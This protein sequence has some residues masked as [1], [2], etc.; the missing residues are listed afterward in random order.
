MLAQDDPDSSLPHQVELFEVG[1]R[2]GLQNE[3][4][5]IPTDIKRSLLQDLSRTG[6]TKVQVTSF[7]NPRL[8]PQLADADVLCAGLEA[9][10]NVAYSALVLN[11]RGLE[12]AMAAGLRHVDLSISASE[13]HSRRNLNRSIG[14]ALSAFRE[15]VARAQAQGLSVQGGI[16]CAFG[17]AYEGW[18]DPKRVLDL[19]E[20]YLETG[21]NELL[22]ADSTGMANPRQV[23]QLIRAVQ[24]RIGPIPLAL[25]LHDTWG[26]GMANLLSALQC[27]VTRYDTAFGG[28]G[29]CPFIPG[30]AGNIAT[31]DVVHMLTEMGISTGVDLAAVLA[32]S[33]RLQQLLERPLPSK[34]HR[35]L[36]PP[37]LAH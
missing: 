7:V 37:K 9:L 4:Q 25:H 36:W 17:C 30:A 19:V 5:F 22:L 24:A 8:V 35:L 18:V 2:D 32:C 28:L 15:T 11:A 16:Q 13:T 14:E 31:E 6:V 12:R 1:L 10:P 34:V 27:G 23:R 21:V 33:A 3:A 20:A 29:G 26:M